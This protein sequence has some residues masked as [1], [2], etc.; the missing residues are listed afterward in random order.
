M[1]NKIMPYLNYS[2]NIVGQT[3]TRLTV[4]LAVGNLARS[5]FNYQFSFVPIPIRG[6]LAENAY[7]ASA[8]LVQR[9]PYLSDVTWWSI[10]ATPRVIASVGSTV[11]TYFNGEEI[12]VS[13][14]IEE[15]EVSTD[16]IEQ[17]QDAIGEPEK[18]ISYVRSTFNYLITKTSGFCAAVA[19]S[20]IGYWVADVGFDVAVY[21]VAGSIPGSIMCYAVYWG[22]KQ[23]ALTMSANT[24]MSFA[25]SFAEKHTVTVFDKVV[26]RTYDA[27]ESAHTFLSRQVQALIAHGDSAGSHHEVEMSKMANS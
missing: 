1:L 10:K 6:I 19:G 21:A 8:S 12:E 20:A 26:D 22:G 9:Y 27:T 16:V 25:H 2:L 24:A 3:A 7:I 18:Q 5:A 11:Q 23:I 14:D 13:T 17:P 15:S 4:P